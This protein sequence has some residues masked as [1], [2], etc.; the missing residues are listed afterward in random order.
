ME[1][2]N[3]KKKEKKQERDLSKD[4]NAVTSSFKPICA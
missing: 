2:N 1:A 4:G 3:E